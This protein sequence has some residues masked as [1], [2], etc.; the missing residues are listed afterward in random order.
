MATFRH[1]PAECQRIDDE[2]NHRMS[3][4]ILSMDRRQ[5][6]GSATAAKI[7][8]CLQ[9]LIRPCDCPLYSSKGIAF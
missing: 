4:W 6:F 1:E 3:G 2:T 7:E 9:L 8:R 5:A